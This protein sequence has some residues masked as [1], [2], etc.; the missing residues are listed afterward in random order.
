MND[1]FEDFVTQAFLTAAKTAALSVVRQNTTVFGQQW[2]GFSNSSISYRPDAIIRS[3][4]GK[5]AGVIDAKYKRVNDER[6]PNSDFY[7]MLAYGTSSQCFRT[8]LFYPASEIESEPRIAIN[9]SEVTIRVCRVD[10]TDE[11]CVRD[12]ELRAHEIIDDIQHRESAL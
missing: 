1:L 8:Y 3:L 2:D 5:V 12:L 10:L 4:E 6:F 7:Q 9:N 11:R